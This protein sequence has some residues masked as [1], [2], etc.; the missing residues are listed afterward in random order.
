M[1]TLFIASRYIVVHEVDQNTEENKNY[2]RNL[3]RSFMDTEENKTFRI[4]SVVKHGQARRLF[5]RFYD[6]YEYPSGPPKISPFYDNVEE[7]PF[8]YTHCSEI[9]NPNSNYVRWLDAQNG[10][11]AVAPYSSSSSSGSL[12]R[13]GVNAVVPDS[14]SSDSLPRAS[15]SAVVPG[16][17]SSNGSLPSTGFRSSQ[18]KRIKR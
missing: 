10:G 12:P 8:E 2:F 13:A 4:T 11:S 7:D 18:R 16:S 5:Y 15:G 1:F 14:S 9:L 17:S 6:I 3:G